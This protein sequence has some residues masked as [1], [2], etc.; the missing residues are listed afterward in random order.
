MRLRS[1]TSRKTPKK[2][3]A[4]SPFAP[5]TTVISSRIQMSAAVGA[6]DP[7]LLHE[8]LAGARALGLVRDHAL[9]VLGVEQPSQRPAS[10]IQ[11]GCVKP[12]TR[13][14]EGLM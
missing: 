10:S 6:P 7:V 11:S 1:V 5:R 4:S 12:S 8:R 3:G 14:I 9:G 13:S 2:S